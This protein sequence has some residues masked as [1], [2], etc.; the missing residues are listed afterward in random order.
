MHDMRRSVHRRRGRTRARAD[1]T[2]S[3]PATQHLHAV[4][5]H[6][7]GPAHAPQ[8]LVG[9][10]KGEDVRVFEVREDVPQ[11]GATEASHAVA[12]QQSGAV[13]RL[14]R[15]VPRWQV[16]DEPPAQSQQRVRQTVPLQ[17]VRQ[18]IRIA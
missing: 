6:V 13:R 18:D 15:G 16:T 1:Q 3:Q 17:G 9:A 10:L 8:A 11:Q 2:R 4:R 7:Q 5:T 14:R 12:P